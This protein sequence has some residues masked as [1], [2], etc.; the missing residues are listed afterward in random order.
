MTKNIIGRDPNKKT[1]TRDVKRQHG[2]PH[3][4]IHRTTVESFANANGTIIKA[5]ELKSKLA[6]AHESEQI[7]SMVEREKLFFKRFLKQRKCPFEYGLYNQEGL[8]LD[9][10]EEVYGPTYSLVGYIEKYCQQIAGASLAA[11]GLNHMYAV[12]QY[13]EE[14]KWELAL[15]HS[16]LALS[17][18]RAVH[19]VVH[20]KLLHAGVKSTTEGAREKKRIA[21]EK[22][23]KAREMALNKIELNGCLSK[24]SALKIVAHEMGW[25][26]GTVIRWFSGEKFNI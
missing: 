2:K 4:S 1:I 23:V 9:N 12:A 8:K 6:E 17:L 13:Y 5:D 3:T 22:K 11:Q 7:L 24:T 20:E 19:L 25:K 15:Q 26:E 21:D 18:A 10:Y 16:L 14:E